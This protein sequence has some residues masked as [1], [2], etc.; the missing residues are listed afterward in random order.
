MAWFDKPVHLWVLS[1]FYDRI[2]CFR[3]YYRYT[4]TKRFGWPKLLSAIVSAPLSIFVPALMKSMDVIPV[5]RGSRNIVK[6]FS[7]SIGALL[8]GENLLISPDIEYANKNS[9]IGQMYDGFLYLEKYYVKKTGRHIP[10]I[11]LHID[12]DRHCIVEG[13]PVYFAG[14]DDFKTGKT[15][16]Y[17]RLRQEFSR[18]ESL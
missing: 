5:F 16:V 6:T 17:E 3:Q 14:C 8:D 9:N 2:E 1:V 7:Q 12:W 11:P 10:Y 18:L 13:N 15:K 4:F